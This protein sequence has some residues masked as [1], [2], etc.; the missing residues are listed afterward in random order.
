M[1]MPLSV[2]IPSIVAAVMFIVLAGVHAY[3][4][5]GGVWPGIDADSLHRTVVGG[6]PG[7]HSPGPTAT[8]MVA[9]IM[10]AAALTVLGGAGLLSLPVPR[11]WLRTSALVGATVL[12]LRGLQG[13][14]DTR[15]RP[16]TAGGPFARLNVWFYS[17]L[18]FVLAVCTALAVRQ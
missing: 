1:S 9:A 16:E 6:A 7:R 8:W 14:V 10:L 13:F 15:M 5:V 3:W 11:R 18:C 12:L 4:A 2:S 17:P